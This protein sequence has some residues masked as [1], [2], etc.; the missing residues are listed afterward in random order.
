MLAD[1]TEIPY[2]Y[3]YTTSNQY[4]D[5]ALLGGDS[6]MEEKVATTFVESWR[7]SVCLPELCL[8]A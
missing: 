3:Y 1:G 4:G 8:I 7:N 2:S 6:A 5:L